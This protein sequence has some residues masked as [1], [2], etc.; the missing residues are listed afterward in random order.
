LGFD[1]RA[2]VH[3]GFRTRSLTWEWFYS[4]PANDVLR[5][6]KYAIPLLQSFH[7]FGLTLVL[8]A[9]AACNA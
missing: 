2:G 8:G 7:L 3:D 6:A 9:T 4:A 1:H 5:N